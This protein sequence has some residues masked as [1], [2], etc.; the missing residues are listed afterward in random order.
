MEQSE[1]SLEIGPSKA[2]LDERIQ[3]L[4]EAKLREVG[5]PSDRSLRESGLGSSVSNSFRKETADAQ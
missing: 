2:P 4:K 1:A 3:L 5:G